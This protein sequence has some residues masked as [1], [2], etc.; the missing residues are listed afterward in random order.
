MTTDLVR[1]TDTS[2]R[3]E[4]ADAIGALRAKAGRLSR[5]DPRRDEIDAAC[6]ELV[7]RW[8]EAEA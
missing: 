1:V 6:D 4:L 8:V 3:A 2:T 7:D 5:H